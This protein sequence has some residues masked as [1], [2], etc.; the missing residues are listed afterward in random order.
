MRKAGNQ[1][2]EHESLI[3]GGV[4]EMQEVTIESHTDRMDDLA[5]MADTLDSA[6][7]ELAPDEDTLD[8]MLGTDVTDAVADAMIAEAIGQTLL[9][10]GEELEQEERDDDNDTGIGGHVVV[11]VTQEQEQELK[12]EEQDARDTGPVPLVLVV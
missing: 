2:H 3:R 4:E 10:A 11:G 12:E 8:E 6:R 9:Q 5:D 1:L 7:D